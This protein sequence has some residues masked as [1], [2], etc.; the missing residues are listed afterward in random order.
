[1]TDQQRIKG[2][3]DGAFRTIQRP[4]SCAVGG[5]SV[6]PNVI[7]DESEKAQLAKELFLC[8]QEEAPNLRSSQPRPVTISDKYPLLKKYVKTIFLSPDPVGESWVD[9]SCDGGFL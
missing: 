9:V 3:L 2:F 4:A 5:V 7:F 1:M 8:I 6:E